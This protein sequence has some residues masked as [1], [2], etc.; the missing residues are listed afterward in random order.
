MV[1]ATCTGCD[2]TLDAVVDFEIDTA[3]AL[4]SITGTFADPVYGSLPW[5]I[6]TVEYQKVWDAVANT[7]YPLYWVGGGWFQFP[8]VTTATAI[9][10]GDWSEIS[11]ATEVPITGTTF[12]GPRTATLRCVFYAAGSPFG[13]ILAAACRP[14]T[15]CGGNGGTSRSV[16]IGLYCFMENPSD[17]TSDTAL[18]QPL[19]TDFTGTV[20]ADSSRY[21]DI[22]TSGV[23]NYTGLGHVS[24]GVPWSLTALHST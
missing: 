8:N 9:A 18:S 7:P 10:A 14:C 24:T 20:C 22:S 1:I 23:T 6:T 4:T 16:D 21:V 11:G 5:T 17:G 13:S 12:Y 15:D 19:A 2:Y 3:T